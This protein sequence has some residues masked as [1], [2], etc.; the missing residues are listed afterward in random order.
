[1][2]FRSI[3]AETKRASGAVTANRCVKF[4]GAQATV[5]G[6]KVLGVAR[7]DA[8]DTELFSVDAIGTAIVE[9]GAA[10]AVGDSLIVDALGRA[11]P[12]TGALVVA[13]GGVAVTSTAVNGAILTGADLPEYVFADAL[14][15]AA[16]LGEKIEVLLRR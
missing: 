2:Q 15:A 1:M 5:Q 12:S 9:A 11:I 6:E 8:A 13:A 7:N 3:H 14:E 4:D 16:A 10:I